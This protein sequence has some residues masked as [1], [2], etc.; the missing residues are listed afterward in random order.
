MWGG[1]GGETEDTRIGETALSGRR[2]IEGVSRVSGSGDRFLFNGPRGVWEET[3]GSNEVDL[4]S[5]D[6][7]QRGATDTKERAR[8]EEVKPISSTGGSD[9]D[10]STVEPHD[11]NT[12][13]EI[14]IRGRVRVGS[15]S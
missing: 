8:A 13:D 9:E 4:V 3:V 6:S 7:W 11:S 14:V 2:S 10:A 12:R 1:E 15:G 5:D